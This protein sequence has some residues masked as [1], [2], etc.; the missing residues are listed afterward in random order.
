VIH[1]GCKATLFGVSYKRENHHWG[2]KRSSLGPSEGIRKSLTESI[3]GLHLQ[4]PQC[5]ASMTGYALEHGIKPAPREGQHVGAGR[6]CTCTMCVYIW[7]LSSRQQSRE[8]SEVANGRINAW[9]IAASFWKIHIPF[10]QTYIYVYIHIFIFLGILKNKF[11]EW[12]KIKAW[13]YH[14]SRRH[15][16]LWTCQRNTTF[17]MTDILFHSS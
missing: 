1:W 14:S 12:W 10:M 8:Y 15:Q 13:E 17:I 6:L 4:C 7:L 2:Y 9:H 5:N 16:F 3:L 11:W